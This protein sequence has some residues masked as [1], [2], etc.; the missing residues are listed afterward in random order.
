[1]LPPA[2][3]ILMKR[4]VIYFLKYY[5]FWFCYFLFFKLFF[6]L[7]NTEKTLTLCFGE[8]FGIFIPGSKMDL[9]AAAYLCVIP[10]ILLAV[11]P[12]IKPNILK[13]ILNFYSFIILVLLTAVGLMDAALYSHWGNRINAQILL[14]LSQPSGIRASLSGWQWFTAVISELGI[15]SFFV[16]VYYRWFHIGTA[17]FHP[18][19]WATT[20]ALLMLS[21]VL[22]IPIRGGLNRAPLNYSSVYFSEN[23]YADQ[24]AYNYFWSF[25]YA[26]LNRSMAKN[27]VHYMD[28]AVCGELMNRSGIQNLEQVPCYLH[29]TPGKPINVVFVILES[30]SN[31]VIEPLGGMPNLTPNLNRL[32]REGIVFTNFYATGTRSDKGISALL[33]SYPALIKASAVMNFPDK[34]KNLDYLPRYFKDHGYQVSFYYGGDINFYNLKMLLMQAGVD[35]IISQSDFPYADNQQK[36]G[37]PDQFLYQKLYDDLE[38][39]TQPFLSMVYNISSHE[40]YDI[41]KYHKIHG[42]CDQE[43]Y[44][45][46]V[47]YTD[48]C[49]GYFIG[50]LQASPL[51]ENTLVIITPDHASSE[52]GATSVEDPATFRVP[53][54]WLG[55]A[56]KAPMEVTSICSQTDLGSTLV[57]QM[58]WK[59]RPSFYA[60]NL[61][62]KNHYAYFYNIN[63]WG[64]LSPG[65]GF[66][67]DIEMK[68]MRYYYGASSPDVPSTIRLTEAYTQYLHND[69]FK[70]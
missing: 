37:I 44:C 51:W 70:R 66:Y 25:S 62:G 50:R 22:V 18:H 17:E 16:W 49:L 69:F 7:Y 30:F 15:V 55:G 19:G 6:L 31:K 67:T 41:P 58:G 4:A 14:Y 35:K 60:K 28:D 56:I 59:P 40:P 33:A 38:Q 24:S 46:A 1:M 57:Q 27:P 63:G 39:S 9:S 61:F 20:P 65:I 10:G 54:L 8:L 2:I 29:R 68:Q 45:N 26:M 32:C 34:L 52:P 23:L 11:S 47:A 42:H 5:L 12:L 36:W 13:I 43:K 21:A 53:L 48:S 64:Y 3:N